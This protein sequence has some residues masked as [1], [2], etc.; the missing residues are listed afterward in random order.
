MVMEAIE[1]QK[2][3]RNNGTIRKL[4]ETVKIVPIAISLECQMARESS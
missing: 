3:Q 4:K 1:V 2:A